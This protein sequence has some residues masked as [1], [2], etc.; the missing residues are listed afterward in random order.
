MKRCI[1]I[2]FLFLGCL[3]ICLAGEAK[4]RL[5]KRMVYLSTN[6]LVDA[7]VTEAVEIL[8][9]AKAAGYNAVALNDYKFRI[10]KKMPERYF[11]NVAAF[12]KEAD[13]LGMEIIP[14]VFPIGYSNGI[15]ANNPNLAAGL[16]VKD[17][18][19][20]VR[21]N[22]ARHVPDPP[23]ALPGG[24]FEEANEKGFV[25]WD[26]MDNF[27]KG[28][29][30]DTRIFH[31][32]KSSV[33]MENIG[34]VNPQHGNSRV[35][36]KIK[37]KP[38]RYY[39]L[40]CRVKTKNFE[41]TRS[42]GMAV[43]SL[44]GGYLTYMDMRVKENQDWTKYEIAFNSLED[45]E[46]RVYVGCWGAKG[47]T[48]WW[49]DA[50][51]REIGLVNVL[52]RDGTPLVVKSEKTGMVYKEGRDFR[53]VIDP[54]LGVIPYAGNYDIYHEPPNIIL[55]PRSRIRDGERLRVSFY[56]PMRIYRSQYMCCPG[57]PEV[58][59]LLRY[60]A[61]KLNEMFSPRGFFM[62]H[63]EI[64]VM[65]WCRACARMGKT[66]GEILAENV[67]RCIAIIKKINPE[68]EIYVW[69][70]MFDPYHNA[71][72]DYYLVKG[73]L[74]GSWEGLSKDVIIMNWYMKIRRKNMPFFEKL[75]HRQVLAGYYDSN[76]ARIKTWLDYAK[77]IEGVIGVMYTTWRHNFDD[78]E[79]F[80]G[81]AWGKDSS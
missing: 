51:L 81:Y 72:K 28:M 62:G 32:G 11:A 42:P 69:S 4:L 79:E 9:K 20:I 25:G 45:E 16:P 71:R 5:E 76:P 61:R 75:G 64:R 27:G 12:K 55:T 68:A 39:Y 3:Q 73:D 65:G 31:S 17:A 57:E 8:K 77:D 78:L 63:D 40:S 58:Y 44:G 41:E 24:G 47:G 80:A 36:K 59:D 23:V 18:L 33:R 50:M 60:E 66:S 53:K 13:A 7:N 15:L 74:A 29:F 6:F 37:V 22:A 1:A 52:R 49:D 67:Q 2:A 19:F 26:W 48:I 21:G 56:H 43:I 54:K 14:C 46:I 34:S 30:L 70:D 10:L 35:V 38:F